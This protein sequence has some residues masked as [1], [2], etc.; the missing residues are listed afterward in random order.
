VPRV[1]AH[2]DAAG[3]GAESGVGVAAA[4]M[5]ME[6]VPGDTGMDSFGGWD[7]HQGETPARFRGKFHA[8]LAGIQAEMAGVR[9]DRIGVVVAVGEGGEG[10]GGGFEVGP[11]PGLGGPFETAVSTLR[12]GRGRLGFVIRRR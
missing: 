11:I 9:F 6:F 1:F 7:V 5:L 10:G 4:F 3:G 8:A 2:D 12:R